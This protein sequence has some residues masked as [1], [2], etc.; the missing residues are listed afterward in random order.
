[1]KISIRHRMILLA[2]PLFILNVSARNSF[3]GG[4]AAEL[5]AWQERTRPQLREMLFNG[6]GP[7][8]SALAP[9][10][11]REESRPDY[12]LREVTFTDRPGHKTHGWLARPRSPRAARLPAVISLH[13]HGATALNT[14]DPEG[15]YLYGDRLAR[16]GSLGLALDIGHDFIDLDRN[17]Q[18]PFLPKNV[19]FPYAGQ[20]VWMAMRGIDLLQS[21]PDA[22][23]D[24]I[25]IVGLSNGGFTSLFTA[26]VDTR[27]KLTVAAGSLI[28]HDRMWR[29]EL[30]HCRCQYL[31]GFDGK[32][33]YYDLAALVAPRALLFQSGIKDPIFP[34]NSA[35]RAFG[36]ARESY[37][38]LGAPDRIGH[39]IHPG[40]HVFI[41]RVPLEWFNRFLPIAG[42]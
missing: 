6:P 35:R 18:T 38:L 5:R 2:L 22:D 20:K 24:A 8:A 3:V 36:Y 12:V 34:I 15:M 4:S 26:A 11:G 7:E 27:I 23:P 33:D 1:M 39:D 17:L 16:Q 14:F 21:L 9:E 10:W 25:G 30:V 41:P 13:G 32:L 28:M 42:K 29:R 19:P 37:E 31:E 40:P